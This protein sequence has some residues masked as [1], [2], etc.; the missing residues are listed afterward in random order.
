MTTSPKPLAQA[1][2]FLW[3]GYLIIFFVTLLRLLKK[4]F[5]SVFL[6]YILI[7]TW[8]FVSSWICYQADYLGKRL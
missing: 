6:S 4:I 5:P 8:C 7:K 1:E 3:S 2:F